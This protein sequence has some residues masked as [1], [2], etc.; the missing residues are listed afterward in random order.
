MKAL[1]VLKFRYLTAPQRLISVGFVVAA[2]AL[3]G[4][5]AVVDAVTHSETVYAHE[6]AA[7]LR[8]QGA[9]MYGAYWC[10]HC[11]DQKAL[12]DSAATNLPYVECDPAGENAK[13][14]LCA[15]KNLQGYPTWEINGELYPGVRSLDELA[16]LSNFPTP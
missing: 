5:S 11:A 10:P 13:P 16:A 8:A 14:Q 1:S 15:A 2:V 7:H 6:I 3:T 9:T 12:F 4:C